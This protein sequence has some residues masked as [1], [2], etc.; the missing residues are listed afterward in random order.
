MAPPEHILELADACAVAV[1]NAVGAA[2]DF[3]QDTLPLVDHWIGLA[4]VRGGALM[5]LL[6]PMAGAYFGEVCRRELEGFRW[7]VDEKTQLWRLE[8]EPRFLYFNPAG[9][10][11]EAFVQEQASGWHAHLHTLP[12]D[13]S[14]LKAL[15]DRAGDVREDD[16]HRLAMRYEVVELVHD[17]MIG[18]AAN[19]G[20]PTHV[21]REAYQAV[22]DAETT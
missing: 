17:T 22:A 10:A 3:S 6:A 4:D 19:D 20:D 1:A 7:H 11:L 12:A 9:V 8:F 5:D 13:E 21:T 16:Y 18:L 15:L 14:V 2:P